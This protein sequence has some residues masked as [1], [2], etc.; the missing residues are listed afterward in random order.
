MESRKRWIKA[1]LYRRMLANICR[2][3]RTRKKKSPFLTTNEI[4]D[5]CEKLMYAK[6]T[7]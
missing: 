5:P 4:T 2:K 3:N 1:L 6:T 7:G